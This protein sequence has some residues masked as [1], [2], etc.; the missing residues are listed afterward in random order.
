MDNDTT[1]PVELAGL[2]LAPWYSVKETA[3]RRKPTF[4]EHA[5]RFQLSQRDKNG[6]SKYVRNIGGKLL[7]SAPGFDLWISE[8]SDYVP[9]RERATA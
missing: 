4:T 7:I 6:L 2:D 8:G 3:A 1:T 5:L 9:Q